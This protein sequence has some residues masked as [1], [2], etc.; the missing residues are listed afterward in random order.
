MHYD[1]MSEVSQKSKSKVVTYMTYV[2]RKAQI[3]LK[4]KHRT[5]HA[6]ID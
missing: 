3:E 1:S 2:K 6:T 4:K 5:A